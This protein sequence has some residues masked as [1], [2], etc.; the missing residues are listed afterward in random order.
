[1]KVKYQ[2]SLFVNIVHIILLYKTI[3]IP[4]GQIFLSNSLKSGLGIN[5]KMSNVEYQFL[6]SYT[7][8]KFN[9]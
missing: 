1:M 2:N 6:L 5:T 4:K 9:Q 3:I 8:E 7:K